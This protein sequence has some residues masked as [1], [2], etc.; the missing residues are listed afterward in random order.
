MAEKAIL[1][2]IENKERLQNRF[3]GDRTGV[4]MAVGY[5]LVAHFGDDGDYDMMSPVNF[6]AK[7]MEGRRLATPGFF[8][9]V[10]RV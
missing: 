9:A 10:P 4:D 6:K 5:Y 1:I 2:T 3:Q 7:Y 8:E